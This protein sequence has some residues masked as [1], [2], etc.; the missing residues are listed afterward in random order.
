MISK[1]T[2]LKPKKKPKPY[3]LTPTGKFKW[4]SEIRRQTA[5]IKREA[6]GW[7]TVGRLFE[8][9]YLINKGI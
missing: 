1:I 7:R 9:L 4:R 2:S 6:S 5:K 3:Y 8:F